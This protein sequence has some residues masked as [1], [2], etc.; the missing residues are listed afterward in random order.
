MRLGGGRQ[1]LA[2]LR[3]L[4]SE[5]GGV[6]MA[7]H[8]LEA[9]VH[10]PGV[11]HIGLAVPTDALEIA[12]PIGGPDLVARKSQLARQTEQIRHVAEARLGAR[13]VG[14]QDIHEIGVPL[15]EAAQVVVPTEAAVALPVLPIAPRHHTV[16]ER[17]VMQHRQVETAAVPGHEVGRVAVDAVE[18]TPHQFTLA[19]VE[20]AEAP[21]LYGVALPQHAGDR[22]HTM[23]LVRQEIAA[24]VPPSLRE[25]RLGDLRVGEAL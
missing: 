13:L 1:Q 2:H 9:Q 15:V 14:R 3:I 8:M 16:L 25:H 18:E 7:A 22:H 4:G 20:V 6:E 17:A 19:R 23:L 5:L 10:E 11:E 12:R 24:R 21:H